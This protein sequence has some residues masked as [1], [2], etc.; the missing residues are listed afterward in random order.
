MRDDLANCVAVAHCG[1][2]YG[3]YHDEVADFSI[4]L[5]LSTPCSSVGCK[6]RVYKLI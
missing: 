2:G 6:M 3:P 5:H 1:C 4:H